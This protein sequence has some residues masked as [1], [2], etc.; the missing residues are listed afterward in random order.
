[1]LWFFLRSLLFADRIVRDGAAIRWLNEWGASLAQCLP[2][3]LSFSK[4]IKL[5]AI[6]ARSN[7][8]HWGHLCGSQ[9]LCIRRR[10][11]KAHYEIMSGVWFVSWRQFVEVFQTRCVW[12]LV[13]AKRWIFD[14]NC[15]SLLER[16]RKQGL[17]Q[18]WILQIQRARWRRDGTAVALENTWWVAS[19][20]QWTTAERT[21][22]SPLLYLWNLVG[23]LIPC[24]CAWF[25]A[26]TLHM[27]WAIGHK[28]YRDPVAEKRSWNWLWML[29]RISCIND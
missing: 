8:G 2:S 18:S 29:T 24:P 21:Q 22:T 14:S 16:N 20:G 1:M 19:K 6:D 10:V 11:L 17:C 27:F 5:A 12:C 25:E 26:T 4:F 23:K 7:T 3:W 13:L 28:V 15:H 9:N